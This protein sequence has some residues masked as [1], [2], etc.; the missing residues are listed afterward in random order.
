M[1]PS[2]GESGTDVD[3]APGV[4]PATTTRA[5]DNDDDDADADAVPRRD[6]APVLVGYTQGELLGRGGMGEIV[7]AHDQRIGRNVAVKRM[8]ENAPSGDA[9]ARFLREAR[10]QARLEHPAIVPVYELGRASDGSPYFTMK[11]LAGVTLSQILAGASSLDLKG[12]LRAFVDVCLAV[13]FAHSRGV[14]HRDL[15]PS[16]IMLGDFGEVYVLDWG[17]A[18]VLDGP[19]A[20]VAT[21]DITTLDGQTQEGSVLGTPGYMPPEQIHGS[22]VGP[23]ADVYALGSILFEMLTGEPLHPRGGALANTLMEPTASPATR[24][25][26]RAIG[27]ELDACCAEA[28]AAD[29][30][31]RPSARELAQKIQRYLDG[32][33]DHERRRTLSLESLAIARTALASGEATRRAEAMTAAGRALALDPESEDAAALVGT[34]MLEVPRELPPELSKHLLDVEVES[35]VKAASSTIYA[36]LSILV[37]LPFL[38]WVGVKSWPMIGA[39][40]GAIVGL[41]ALSAWMVHSRRAHFTLFMFGFAVMMILFTRLFGPFV[42]VPGILGVSSAALIAQPSFVDRPW[43]PIG[44]AIAALVIPL[45]FEVT[46]VF[47]ATWSLGGDEL[48]I[49]SAALR[50]DGAGA[51]TMLVLG[52]ISLIV[53]NGLY[54]HTLASAHRVA[55][56]QLEVQAWHLRKLLPANASVAQSQVRRAMRTPARG[57]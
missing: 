48:K 44:V 11:R 52:N 38:W 9:L 8:R 20:A 10:I 45:V 1:K 6:T 46:G 27:P 35:D 51:I 13:E 43:L 26:G 7:L 14:V 47:D 37:F 15:K 17:V 50:L 54:A 16:N 49:S 56:R 29:P 12:M 42:L 55:T 41:V 21:S 22:D 53:I 30:E 24:Q 3:L 40:I 28:L 34:L 31:R 23:R 18:R 33:R 57:S 2:D 19:E 39:M 5:E 25:P 4:T 32:D 36:L